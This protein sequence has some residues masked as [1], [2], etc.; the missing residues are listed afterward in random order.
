M[1]KER[2]RATMS[3]EDFARYEGF[4]EQIQEEVNKLKVTEEENVVDTSKK[5]TNCLVLKKVDTD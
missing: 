3:P 5:A 2:R 1:E 4:E